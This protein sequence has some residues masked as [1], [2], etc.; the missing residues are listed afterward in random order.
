MQDF[1]LVLWIIGFP[2]GSAVEKYLSAKRGVKN[3]GSENAKAFVALIE[4]AIW[5]GM[6]IYLA[7]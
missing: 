4:M 5:I 2:L 1:V 6:W 3:E 7:K